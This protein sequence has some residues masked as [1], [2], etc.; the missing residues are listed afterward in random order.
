MMMEMKVSRVAAMSHDE[1]PATKR[2]FCVFSLFFPN[3]LAHWSIKPFVIRKKSFLRFAFHALW[4]NNFYV[5]VESYRAREKK[6]CWKEFLLR[7]IARAV[8]S[9]FDWS[10]IELWICW[11]IASLRSFKAEKSFLLAIESR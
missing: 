8:I 5:R 11:I 7:C 1:K 9:S 2:I 3:A 4:S 6:I 10:P